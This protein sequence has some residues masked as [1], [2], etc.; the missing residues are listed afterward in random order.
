VAQPTDDPKV[1]ILPD[2][3]LNPLLN[4][5]LVTHM[6][7]WAEVYFTSPPEKRAEAV[8]D[9]VRELANNSVPETSTRN[10]EEERRHGTL[11]H[12]HEQDV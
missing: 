5:L 11:K 8:S 1:R 9:L 12:Q 7:R 10:N 2:S 6:G 3:E 4:P